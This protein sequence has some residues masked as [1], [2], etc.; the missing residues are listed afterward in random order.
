MNTFS[1]CILVNFFIFLQNIFRVFVLFGYNKIS[2][3][4]CNNN[5]ILLPNNGFT[6][7]W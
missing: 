5:E 1:T 6:A 7:V 2:L 4:L 3:F